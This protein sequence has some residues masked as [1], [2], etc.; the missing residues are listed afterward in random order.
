MAAPRSLSPSIPSFA[1]SPSPRDT[2]A[3]SPT[4]HS[5]ATLS[6]PTSRLPY[7]ANRPRS[8]SAHLPAHARTDS[9]VSSTSQPRSRHSMTYAGQ[10]PVINTQNASKPQASNVT[11]SSSSTHA[12]GILPPASFFRPS[13][14]NYYQPP[15]P[16]PRPSSALSNDSSHEMPDHFPLATLEERHDNKSQASLGSAAANPSYTAEE[17][18]REFES[19]RRSKSSREPL[20]PIGGSAKRSANLTLP[21][22]SNG[23][24]QGSSRGASERSQGGP[25]STTSRG[26]VRDSMDRMEKLLRQGLSFD[27]IRRS[28][29]ISSPLSPG[30]DG[31][32]QFGGMEIDD[33]DRVTSSPHSRYHRKSVSPATRSTPRPHSMYEFNP[34]P[35]PDT[36]PPLS[37]VPMIDENTGKPVRNYQL[38][39]S[40][41]R[42]FFSG[43]F[44][45]GG[46]SPWAFVG[47]SCVVLSITGV[48]FGTTCVWWWRHKSPAVAIVGAYMCLLTI[49]CMLATAFRDPGILPRNLDPDPPYPATPPPDGGVKAPLPRDLRVRTAYV[50]VKYCPTCKI[51]RPPRS[52]HCK[53]CDNCVDGCDHHC[54]WVNNCV[55]RRNYT[56]FFVFLMSAVTTSILIIITAALHLYF[57]TVDRHVD[58]RQALNMGAGSAVVFAMTIIVIWPVT[59]LLAYHMRLL[60]LNVTTIE[61]IRN[62]ALK[63]LAPGPAPY[64]PFSH[65]NWRRNLLAVLCRPAGYSWLDGHAVATEDKRRINPGMGAVEDKQ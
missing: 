48:W 39:P 61:Q 51:Y 26:R 49:S 13:R 43:R 36:N 9:V 47:S 56:F 5:P 38:H 54:Q 62:Q 12:T 25:S 11:P 20:L 22:M 8:G 35:P 27:H 44:L 30:S 23:R 65:G 59:A 41:N 14:P 6:S 33:E 37:A 55:G 34:H 42:F 53:M 58:F 10:I 3:P 64:N 4:A 24:G 16:F 1:R 2:S 46:D 7:G 63:S 31:G 50:R 45:T 18:Q 21:G 60:L 15:P 29:S 57:L 32:L 17:T 40:R 28:P 52:S 19:L